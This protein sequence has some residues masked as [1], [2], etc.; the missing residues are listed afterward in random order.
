MDSNGQV[1]NSSSNN[2]AISPDGRFV[3]F[4]SYATILVSGDTNGHADIFVHDRQTGVTERVSVSSTGEQGNEE[5]NSPS[6]S[7][8]G[9]YV[10][11]TSLATNLVANDSTERLDIFVHDR[12]LNT[13]QQVSLSSEGHEANY[14]SGRSDISADGRY[15]T[16]TSGAT[17]LVPGLTSIIARVFVHDRQ[18]G[19]TELV[20]IGLNGQEPDGESGEQDIT[21]SSGYEIVFASSASNLVISNTNGFFHDAFVRFRPPISLTLNYSDGAPGS[22]F[23]LTGSNF[24]LTATATIAV[25]GV[26]IGSVPTDGLG[27]FVCRLDTT[28]A[29]PG[30]YKVTVTA[31]PSRAIAYFVLEADGTVRPLE[32]SGPILPVPQFT[33][34]YAPAVFR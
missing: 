11:F 31:R 34:V 17:N 5:S 24:P 32:D 23:S 14:N 28:G 20:S 8:D 6:I 13:T 3:A 21:G 15:V 9:R 22:F 25:N 30:L 33:F 26:V 10:S 1:G 27:S 16:F 7:A 12:W 4:D 2:P 18:T 19:A 29:T